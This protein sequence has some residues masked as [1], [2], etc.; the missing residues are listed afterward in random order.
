[1]GA[2]KEINQTSGLYRIM[3]AQSL[4]HPC[5]P[6]RHIPA[7]LSSLCP[8]CSEHFKSRQNGRALP[9][10]VYLFT[11]FMFKYRALLVNLI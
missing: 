9:P 11:E 7:I 3:S 2:I 4:T 1:M 5:A 6:R 10:S 8:L